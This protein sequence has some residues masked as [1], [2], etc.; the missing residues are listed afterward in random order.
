MLNIGDFICI[1]QLLNYTKNTTKFLQYM[2]SHKE[3]SV[4][5][6]LKFVFFETFY[7]TA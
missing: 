7:V 5:I 4:Y 3:R 6:V 2:R 1:Q